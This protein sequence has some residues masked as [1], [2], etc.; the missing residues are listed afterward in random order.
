MEN[1]KNA[2]EQCKEEFDAI[3]REIETQ[4]DREI[5]YEE[6]GSLIFKKFRK[7]DECKALEDELK[8]VEDRRTAEKPI[9]EAQLE[10]AYQ[11]YQN[12]FLIWIAAR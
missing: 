8:L 5:S 7:K 2:I 11:R 12:A 9:R 3:N 10:R 1:A 4:W 6:R